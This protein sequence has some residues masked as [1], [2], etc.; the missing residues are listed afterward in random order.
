MKWR[1]FFWTQF[2]CTNLWKGD[3]LSRQ[4]E[5]FDLKTAQ[6]PIPERTVGFRKRT[7]RKSTESRRP[8]Q[9]KQCNKPVMCLCVWFFF[10]FPLKP[11]EIWVGTREILVY[12][13][14]SSCRCKENARGFPGPRH[15]QCRT[16][17]NLASQTSFLFPHFHPRKR[18]PGSQIL[19]FCWKH[20]VYFFSHWNHPL[21]MGFLF[22]VF[23]RDQWWTMCVTGVSADIGYRF[24][25]PMVT[26]HCDSPA[27]VWLFDG[28]MLTLVKALSILPFPPSLHHAVAEMVPAFPVRSLV[29]FRRTH[30]T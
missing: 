13:H 8:L 28:R 16:E 3:I 1:N 24:K 14:H 20:W 2:E 9:E 19:S 29:S 26:I 12:L 7:K 15:I 17:E 23:S 30:Q 10:K 21:K 5:R 27:E 4:V 18:I 11:H 25:S 22:L 6:W